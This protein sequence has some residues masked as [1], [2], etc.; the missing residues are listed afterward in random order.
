MNEKDYILVCATLAGL[1]AGI[2]AV[3]TVLACY[4][5]LDLW[6]RYVGYWQPGWMFTSA[7]CH[8]YGWL[9]LLSAFLGYGLTVLVFWLDIRRK[10]SRRAS[11]PG[12]LQI[13]S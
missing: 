13:F 10:W 3:L 1:L 12:K 8:W 4:R 11:L 5:R 6:A 9:G 2:L 7:I